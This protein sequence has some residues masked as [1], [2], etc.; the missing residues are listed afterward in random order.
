MQIYHTEA[1]YLTETSAQ[2]AGNIIQGFDNYLKNQTITRR[3]NEVTDADR[4]FS[5]SSATYQRVRSP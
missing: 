5:T 4:M 2:G 1:T 3:R